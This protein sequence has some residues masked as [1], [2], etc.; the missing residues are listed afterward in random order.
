VSDLYVG[1]SPA[2]NNRRTIGLSQVLFDS[3]GEIREDFILGGKLRSKT[4]VRR[5]TPVSLRKGSD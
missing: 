1:F 3:F 2:T 5:Q 4:P